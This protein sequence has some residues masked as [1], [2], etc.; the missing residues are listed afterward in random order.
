MDPIGHLVEFIDKNR[1]ILGLVQRVRG[2]RLAILSAQDKQMAL[3]LNRCLLISPAAMDPGRPRHALTAYLSQVESRRREL[4]R[5]VDVEGLW[6]LVHAED[7][8]VSLEDLAELQFGEPAG[9]DQQSAVLRALF[10]ERLHFKLSGGTFVPLSP[11]QLE[12]KIHQRQKEAAHRRQVD[13][14]VAYLKSLPASGPPPEAAPDGLLDLLAELVV[15]EDD[16]PRARMA[17]EIVSLAEVGGRRRLFDL[18]VR[19]GR[20][21]PH[22]NLPLLK[23]GLSPQ[24]PP[25]VQERALAVDPAQALDEGREDLTGLYTFTID[26]QF[27]TDFDDAL[28]FEPDLEGGGVL[29]VHITDAAALLPDHDLLDLEARARGTTI[30]LPD[31]RVPMLPPSLSEDALSLKEDQLRPTISTFVHLDQQGRVVDFRLCR[32]VLRVHRRLTYDEADQMLEDDPRLAALYRL[33]RRLKARRGQ[34]GAYFLPL[35]E[36]IV[37][38]DEEN[39]VYV[40]RIDRDGPSREMVAETAIVANQ[41][42]ARFLDQAGAPA[43]Y[44]TQAPPREPIEE[45]DPGDIFLHFRQRRLL[46]RVEITTKPG[47]HSSLGVEPYTHLTSPI[48]RYLDLVMQRQLGALLSGR[49]PVYSAQ[50]LERVAMEVEPAVRAGMR[51]RQARQRYWLLCWL[52]QRRQQEHPAIVM[53]YQTRRWQLLLPEIMM[54]TTIPNQPG[55]ALEPGQQVGVRIEKVD[56]FHDQLRVRLA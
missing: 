17:K 38:V 18:L 31:T 4:S 19:L 15:L 25:Q 6:E 32:S 43:L 53:E 3:P 26:G 16:A 33:S 54:L 21:Q 49:E 29:G 46:N 13:R 42:A 50:E 11:E 30:Y 23:E 24:F 20:F 51:V 40:R 45:G 5:Q 9:D 41:M 8:P 47:L 1:I 14:A 39:Q 7:D 37:G 35:P 56:A 12:K 44:R 27:T 52:E 22:E 28:S 2:N 48:R 10:D 36:L 55:L 34:N